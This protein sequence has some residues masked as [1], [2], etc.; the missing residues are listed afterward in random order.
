MEGVRLGGNID[1][2]LSTAFVQAQVSVSVL[3]T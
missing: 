3:G 1:L 2:A